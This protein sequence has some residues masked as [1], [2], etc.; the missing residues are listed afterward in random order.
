MKN[1]RQLLNEERKKTYV[2][3]RIEPNNSLVYV[4]IKRFLD[5]MISL[6]VIILLCIPMLIVGLII[7]LES[8]GPAIF[9]QDRLG[10]NS[11][12]FIMY[13]FRT[14]TTDAEKDGPRWAEKNDS[15]CTKV[16]LFLRK[17]RIDELPQFLNVIK[18]DMS[19]VGPRPER[20]YFY[21][22]FEKYIKGFSNRLVVLPGITGLAQVS[23]GY[24]LLPEEKIIY[25]MEYISK[26]SLKMDFYCIFKTI[27]VIFTHDGAR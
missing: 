6:G 10:K 21:E 5:F 4:C 19:L 27:S 15:R 12:P 26:M 3:E 25:D 1:E 23:G 7:R 2:I 8:P 9:K 18:G 24:D 13:K 16:G 20:E 14:M 22:K 17:T 11:K